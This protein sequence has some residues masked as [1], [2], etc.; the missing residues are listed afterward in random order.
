VLVGFIGLITSFFPPLRLFGLF[1]PLIAVVLILVVYSY[2]AY[3]RYTVDGKEPLSP[4]FLFLLAL[5]V[6]AIG[7]CATVF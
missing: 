6:S 2:I 3:Q 4:P 1:V 7:S 5:Y